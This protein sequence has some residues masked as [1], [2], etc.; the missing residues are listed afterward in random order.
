M[1]KMLITALVTLSL[2]LPTVAM[3]ANFPSKTIQLIVP[4]KPG[5]GSD[6][7]ARIFAQCLGKT[8]LPE[9]VIV[10]NINGARGKTGELETRR[11]R[12]DGYTL[13][14]QHQSMHI[15]KVT[16]RSDYTYKEFKPVAL[17]TNAN[18][19]LFVSKNLGINTAKELIERA[20]A[21]P[22]SITV[23]TAINGVSHFGVLTFMDKAGLTD[24]DLKIVGVSGDKKRIIATLQGNIHLICTSVSSAKPYVESGDLVS[25]GILSQ[26]RDPGLPEAPTMK[27]QGY[28]AFLS[29][30]Y[31]TYAPSGL[32]QDVADIIAAA[33]K[34]AANDPECKTKMQINAANLIWSQGTELETQLQQDLNYYQQLAIKFNLAPKK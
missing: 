14:W 18:W 16:G 8:S 17:S 3:S 12:P 26:E 29:T 27:E 34:E 13:L 4:Y 2:C 11:S 32:P 10:K 15:A 31:V 21:E 6:V 25:L 20:K 9:K 28:E 30:D 5:G 1:S 33:W 22:R 24:Q 23:G 19:G 7:T